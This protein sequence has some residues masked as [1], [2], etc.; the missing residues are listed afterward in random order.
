MLGH[1]LVIWEGIIW[2]HSLELFGFTKQNHG[3]KLIL[4]KT[5]RRIAGIWWNLIAAW[6]AGFREE[7]WVVSKLLSALFLWICG[8]LLSIGQL[9]HSPLQ[10]LKALSAPPCF[11]FCAVFHYCGV[12]SGPS[13]MWS[14]TL[15][16]HHVFTN[17]TSSKSLKIAKGKNI[18][19]I[20]SPGSWLRHVEALCTK[21]II[22]L[23][24]YH[25]N[26]Y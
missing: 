19:G 8:P 24:V 12:D 20:G 18:I 5:T 17:S 21:K 3:K 9:L 22:V 15:R 16:I 13:S 4:K 6:Q 2:C 7:Y 26:L 1:F 14:Y 23:H 10:T 11:S 25:N